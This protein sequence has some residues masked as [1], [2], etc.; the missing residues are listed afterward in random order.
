MLNYTSYDQ[1]QQDEGEVGEVTSP[2][3]AAVVPHLA[4]GLQ[5]RKSAR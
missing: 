3:A 5:H 1:L 2:E 4:D